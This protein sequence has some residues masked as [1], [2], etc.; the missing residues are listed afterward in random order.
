MKKIIVYVCL[1]ALASIVFPVFA[2][3]KEINQSLAKTLQWVAASPGPGLPAACWFCPLY[4]QIFII[5]NRVA[6][7]TANELQQL[8]QIM[9]WIGGFAFV[10]FYVGKQIVSLKEIPLGDFWRGLAIP[11]GKIIIASVLLVNVHAIYYFIINPALTTSINL[12]TVL[13]RRENSIRLIN[14]LASVG[15]E[16][17]TEREG[18]EKDSAEKTSARENTKAW[19]QVR[20]AT[21]NLEFC[22][23]ITDLP[24][25]ATGNSNK[26]QFFENST[27]KSVQCMMGR[28]N[29]TFATGFAVGLSISEWAW[30]SWISRFRAMWLGLLVA[31]SYFFLMVFLGMK[32]IDPLMRLTIVCALMPLWIV[33]WAIPATAG[34]TK[35]AWETLIN[36][37]AIFVMLSIVVAIIGPLMSNALG[38][39][40]EVRKLFAKM[41]RGTVSNATFEYFDWKQALWCLGYTLISFQMINS[42]EQLAQMFASG[43][44]D[45]GLSKALEGLTL[46]ITALG[47]NLLKSGTGVA[48]SV[49]HGMLV[50]GKY[51]WESRQA[52]KAAREQ[53]AAD[54]EARRRDEEARR[55]RESADSAGTHTYGSGRGSGSGGGS[56]P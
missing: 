9:L 3:G 40:E 50:G 30:P 28:A 37:M 43:G 39:E 49:G 27:Y 1:I 4:K 11:L 51:A 41:L 2:E 15:V 13:V 35:K 26:T 34:Y 7:D 16:M 47:S 8:F 36:V 5:L 18:T 38:P 55:R 10:V 46:K 33:L 21:Q 44:G 14:G 22:E 56:A 19:Q 48:K 53:A 24:E 6:V 31:G 42:V 32:I 52:T 54:A 23:G 17:E 12:G 29:A 20:L 25:L 45:M